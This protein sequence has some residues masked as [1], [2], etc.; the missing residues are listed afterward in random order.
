MIFSTPCNPS[1]TVYTKAELEKFAQVIAAHPNM[2]VISD[3]IY[4]HI[5]FIGKHESLAQF[6]NVRN[7]VITVNGVK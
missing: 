2:Y 7:Q 4:E 5:N 3:E 1:G 6:E